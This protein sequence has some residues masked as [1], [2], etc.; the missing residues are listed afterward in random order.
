MSTTVDFENIG[1]DITETD[2]DKPYAEAEEK[3]LFEKEEGRHQ[4]S[5]RTLKSMHWVGL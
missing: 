2:P 5:E 3:R 1:E 4:R